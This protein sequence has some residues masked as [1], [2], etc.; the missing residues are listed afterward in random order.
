MTGLAYAT[1]ALVV[2]PN[3]GHFAPAQPEMPSSR[4]GTNIGTACPAARCKKHAVLTPLIPAWCHPSLVGRRQTARLFAPRLSSGW[5]RP[6]DSPTTGASSYFAV[7]MCASGSDNRRHSGL[8]HSRYGG[9]MKGVSNTNNPSGIV[10][11]FDPR[12]LRSIPTTVN[13]GLEL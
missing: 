13:V 9:A 10:L 7:S 11:C 5:S 3:I 12:L 2:C 6:L 1:V 4:P 8:M